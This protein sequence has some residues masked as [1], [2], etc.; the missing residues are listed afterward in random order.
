MLLV[1]SDTAINGPGQTDVCELLQEPR[2]Q[3]VGAFNISCEKLCSML[4]L[5][6]QSFTHMMWLFPPGRFV[7]CIARYTA[8]GVP[9]MSKK[10][11]FFFCLQK[12]MGPG[13]MAGL[14]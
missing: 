11:V 10:Q 5:Q 2:D 3:T 4:S 1:S 13:Q 9:M 6:I 14:P 12:N 8:S 7:Y